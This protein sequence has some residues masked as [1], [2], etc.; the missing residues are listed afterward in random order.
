MRVE[1]RRCD[2]VG[3]TRGELPEGLA[4]LHAASDAEALRRALVLEGGGYS[5]TR[6]EEAVTLLR[7]HH[8]EGQSGAVETA[9]LLCTDWRWSRCTA[10]LIN[11]IT[12]S[13]I[14]DEPG[15]DAL[16]E[17]L[18]W[19]DRAEYQYPIGWIGTKWI[20]IDLDVGGKDDPEGAEADADEDG[21][22]DG[23]EI[24][25]EIEDGF[26]THTYDP[27]TPVRADRHIAPPLRRW[28]AAR[29]LRRQPGRLDAVVHRAESLEALDAAAVVQGMIDAI[30]SL[31]EADARRVIALGL[32]SGRGAVR[33]IALDR[34]AE[35]DGV[36]AAADLAAGDADAKV[37][38][39]T[40]P[41]PTEQGTVAE[42]EPTLFDG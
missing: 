15:L 34:L 41:V 5:R 28:A 40:P 4:A 8:S 29:V 21:V 36:A 19:P 12:T 33:L 18:L 6:H 11:G 10:K 17:A 31:D 13:G 2:P 26:V 23:V 9:L 16:A 24:E 3:D 30:G 7:W 35:R 37:R 32:R 39:W 22:E 14:L 20:V 1:D 42:P 27:Q 38:R 25:I